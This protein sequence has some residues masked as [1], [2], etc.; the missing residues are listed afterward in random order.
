MAASAACGLAPALGFLIG[1]RAVQGTAAAIMLPASLALVRQAYA[2]P[3]RRAKAIAVWAVGGTV[4][5][6][7]G[8]VA[9]GALTSALSW[10]AIFF[11]NLRPGWWPWPC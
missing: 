6:A 7:A 5:L 3:A 1:S 4:A 10:R 8:P 11:L 2:D 9:G